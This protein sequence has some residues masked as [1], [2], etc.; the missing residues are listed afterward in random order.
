MENVDMTSRF[1]NA[2]VRSGDIL[3]NCDVE[4]LFGYARII[5]SYTIFSVSFDVIAYKRINAENCSM[6]ERYV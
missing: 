1:I 5:V 4:L 2:Y 3:Y 6:K